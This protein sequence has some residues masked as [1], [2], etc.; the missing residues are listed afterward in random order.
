MTTKTMTS[1]TYDQQN[2]IENGA[3]R[4]LDAS[5]SNFDYIFFEVNGDRNEGRS[6]ED[7]GNLHFTVGNFRVVR[8]YGQGRR[9]QLALVADRRQ[10]ERDAVAFFA[11]Y[12]AQ[13][14]ALLS[15]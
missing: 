14:Q 2:A 11:Q 5:R 13:L 7:D 9:Q 12:G 1:F 3:D 4:V 15:A 8:E 10:F 6:V